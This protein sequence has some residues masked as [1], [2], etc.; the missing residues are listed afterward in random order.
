[1]SPHAPAERML[2][3]T[4]VE[5]VIVIMILALVSAIAGP[6]FFDRGV[7][8]ERGFYDETVSAVRYAQK[9]AVA[10]GCTVRVN[11]TAT[12]FELFCAAAAATCNTA[13]FDTPVT[14]PSRPGA[15][16]SRTA[17]GGVA[18]TPASFMFSAL[19]SASANATVNVG[20]RS[21]SVIAAT[22]FVQAP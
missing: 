6:R 1:M 4:L 20:G 13:P 15:N 3:F 21:F 16:F 12:G 10:T 14:D 2:G 17:P 19:G 22:G 7:F 8:E 9:L 11:I 18:L 5:L